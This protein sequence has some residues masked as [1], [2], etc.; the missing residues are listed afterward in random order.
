[1]MEKH[2]ISVQLRYLETLVKIGADQNTTTLF[3]IPMDLLKI[4]SGKNKD[5]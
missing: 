5:E 4:F 1:M 2:P 3:P